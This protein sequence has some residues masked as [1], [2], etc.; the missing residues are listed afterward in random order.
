MLFVAIF[1]RKNMKNHPGRMRNI[2]IIAFTF[3]TMLDNFPSFRP[4]WLRLNC[5]ALVSRLDCM[6][7]HPLHL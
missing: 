2:T 6:E 4:P 7:N 1:F 3:S 5:R